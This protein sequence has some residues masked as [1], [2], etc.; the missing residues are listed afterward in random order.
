MF[1]V[2][3][4]PEPEEMLGKYHI[5]GKKRREGGKESKREDGSVAGL[6]RWIDGWRDGRMDGWEDGWMGERMDGWADGW[7]EGW[8]GG[9][10]DG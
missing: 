1:I 3:L 8:M 7:M 5:E 6:E 2:S 9:R 10:M 4:V